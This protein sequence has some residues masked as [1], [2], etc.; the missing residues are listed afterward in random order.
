MPLT[1][2][3]SSQAMGHRSGDISFTGE[4]SETHPKRLSMWLKVTPGKK[5]EAQ[6]CGP[7][8]FQFSSLQTGIRIAFSELIGD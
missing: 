5:G 1:S 8:Q 2:W 4:A 7:L 6:G 3:G